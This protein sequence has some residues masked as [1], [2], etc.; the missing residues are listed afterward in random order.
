MENLR[1]YQNHYYYGSGDIAEVLQTLAGVPE[2]TR[3]DLD[4]AIFHLQC[5]AQNSYN[6]DYFRTFFN[7][8]Q[9]ITERREN[10]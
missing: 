4:E 5:C 2:D 7:I 8:L 1:T 10:A 6:S 3:A 9:I